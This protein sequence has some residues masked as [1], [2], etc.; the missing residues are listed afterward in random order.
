MFS[1]QIELFGGALSASFDQDASASDAEPTVVADWWD[2][3]GK[4]QNAVAHSRSFR[5]LDQKSWESLADFKDL[6][7]S[8]QRHLR[9]Q[10]APTPSTM[11]VSGHYAQAWKMTEGLPQVI[12]R[13]NKMLV[14]LVLD[15]VA[16]LDALDT[17]AEGTT[18]P[19]PGDSDDEGGDE[20][21]DDDAADQQDSEEEKPA[22]LRGA[23]SDIG[24]RSNLMLY[25]SVISKFRNGPGIYKAPTMR[26]LFLRLLAHPHAPLQKLALECLLTWKSPAITERAGRLIAL[27]EDA[28]FRETLAAIDLEDWRVG[29]DPARSREFFE[30]LTSI[31]YGK[32]ISRTVRGRSAGALKARRNAIVRF[33]GSYNDEELQILVDMM[34]A[35]FA[36]DSDKLPPMRI[37]MGFL[38]LLGVVTNQLRTRIAPFLSTIMPILHRILVRTAGDGE[39]ASPE[40]KAAKRRQKDARNIAMKRITAFFVNGLKG[41]ETYVPELFQV[42]LDERVAKF[43]LENVESPSPTLQLL[44]A[45]STSEIY[46]PLLTS[47][48]ALLCTVFETLK[49]DSVSQRVVTTILDLAANLATEFALLA[50]PTDKHHAVDMLVAGIEHV[51]SKTPTGREGADVL[52]KCVGLLSAAAGATQDE[53]LLSRVVSL[54]LPSLAKPNRVVSER[55]KA[56]IFA[57]VGNFV[58]RGPAE[59]KVGGAVKTS[60]VYRV[61]SRCFSTIESQAGR[62]ALDACFQSFLAVDPSLSHVA[63]LVADM[64][65]MSA[66]RIDEPDFDRRFAAFSSISQELYRNLTSGEWLPLLHNLIF[67]VRDEKEF[68]VRTNSAYCIVKL[69]DRAAELADAKDAGFGDHRD[70]VVYVLLPAIK[71][72][73]KTGSEAVRNEFLGLLAHAVKRLGQEEQF[74]DMSCLIGDGDEDANV[75]SNLTHMQQHRR[76]RGMKKLADR[77]A[78]GD[79]RPGTL[80]QIFFPYFLHV[81]HEYDRSEEHSLITETIQNLGRMA[82]HLSWSAYH[83]IL[84]AEIGGVA[85][86]PDREKSQIR[87]V[88]ALLDSFSYNMTATSVDPA[89]DAPGEADNEDGEEEE[90]AQL[91]ASAVAQ[92]DSAQKIHVAVV[93]RLL[94]EL[95]KLLNDKDEDGDADAITLRVPIALAIAGL[96]VKLP[97]Q[98]L[99]EQL[100]KLLTDLCQRL[101][102]FSQDLRDITRSTLVKITG[103]LG[104]SH[105]LFTVKELKTALTRGPQLHVLAY[106]VHAI[107]AAMMSSLRPGDLD[108]CL[109]ELSGV[110]KQ[111][112]FGTVA[113]EKDVEEL[114]K[115]MRETKGTK[116]YD[117]FELLASIVSLSHVGH[118]LRP[119]REAMEESTQLKATNAVEMSLRRIASGLASNPSINASELLV[120]VHGMLSD[121]LPKAATRPAR[122]DP[123][124]TPEATAQRN[125]ELNA[126]MMVVFA[127]LILLSGLRREQVRL[128]NEDNLRMLDPIVRLLASAVSS[129]H[130]G[131]TVNALK[132]LSIL[133]KTELPA[134]SAL[135]EQLVQSVFKTL[136]RT[137]NLGTELVQQALKFLS[138][139]IRDDDTEL[140]QKQVSYLISMIS[141][142]LEETSTQSTSFALIKAIVARKFISEEVYDLLDKVAGLLVTSQSSEVR[143]LCRQVWLPFFLD[144]PQSPERVRKQLN[145]LVTNLDYVH[146]TGRES[147][148]EML[149]VVCRKLPADTLNEYVQL[150]TLALVTKMVADEST[151]CRQMASELVKTILGR[152]ETPQLEILLNLADAW[153][154]SKASDGLKIAAFQLYGILADLAPQLVEPLI[155]DIASLAAASLEVA[156]AAEATE[157]DGGLQSWQLAYSALS[158][159][160]KLSAKWYTKIAASPSANTLWTAVYESLIHGHAW[161]RLAASRL[162]SL[163]LGALDS[164][165]KDLDVRALFNLAQKCSGQ[166]RSSVLSEEQATQTVKNMFLLAKIL[167]KLGKGLETDEPRNDDER[168]LP[169][170]FLADPLA[171]MILKFAT[172]ARNQGGN[173]SAFLTV[174]LVWPGEESANKAD[175]LRLPSLQ[176]ASIFRWF[177]AIASFVNADIGEEVL[178]PMIGA[179]Y[180]TTQSETLR[181]KD[182]E[183]LKVTAQEVL[184]LLQNKAGTDRYLQIYNKVHLAA[185]NKR[186]ARHD[187]KV[188][189]AVADPEKAAKRKIQRNESKRDAKKRKIEDRKYKKLGSKQKMSLRSRNPE[190]RI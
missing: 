23:A 104:P 43:Q 87:L 150:I 22:T 160:V 65:A 24:Y 179:L 19:E 171:W 16:K 2:S 119:L 1:E 85:K 128:D 116:S 79:L 186:Q 61:V 37:Q 181:G 96:L 59:L 132:I 188:T 26:K 126:H 66:K 70:L 51:L 49:L 164:A 94:P 40:L 60:Q 20:E 101:R 98:S 17:A 154:N 84:R 136:G 32:L 14:G 161:V 121:M 120:L 15:T 117:T 144:Y 134:M 157:D 13:H 86:R 102:S 174:S 187:T 25:L 28:K 169:E 138:T 10:L 63:K 165:G 58:A 53:L 82:S 35:P 184:D 88:V 57:V 112:L 45:W 140:S 100:P 143:A 114:A 190:A 69:I 73:M 145:F 106:T 67:S 155:T 133:V 52:L 135:K 47:R 80:A 77:A 131:V 113:E 146:E 50:N 91:A 78:A 107:V 153:A 168:P 156:V 137:S 9:E 127:E 18:A 4:W 115:K 89:A 130:S 83:T 62:A 166:L 103:L 7:N 71:Q 12:E 42:Y 11:A 170:Q 95:Y 99:K 44:L 56:D 75:F 177:A 158:L 105:F 110:L 172:N 167:R 90:A 151:K 55:V 125:L 173:A 54:L 175:G 39:E 148:M 36:A 6:S 159:L 176:R 149:N 142:E 21:K 162:V 31:M 5:R 3:F 97:E 76:T 182:A 29:L 108:N 123:L 34:A 152:L 141:P 122:L 33:L 189:L 46:R 180:H 30:V 64:N 72:S 74:A 92:A 48:Q 41:L 147:A 163:R 185:M 38:N 129:K 68:S 178:L 109:E 81:V 8:V 27:T 118:L 139:I 111:D 124:A 93:N 183:E